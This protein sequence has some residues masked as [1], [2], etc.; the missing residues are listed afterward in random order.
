MENKEVAT[1]RKITGELIGGFILYSIPFMILYTFI[2]S[3]I[4]SLIPSSLIL[5]GIISIFLQGLIVF[6]IWKCSILTTFRK[7]AINKDDVPTVMKNLFIFTFILCIIG[8]V[9]FSFDSTKKIN[10]NI[11]KISKST[12]LFTN[13]KSNNVQISQ[14]KLEKEKRINEI[15]T[16]QYIYLAILEIGLFIVYIGVVPLQ[17]KSI[18]KYAL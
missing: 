18:L 4:S 7:R 2:F 8:I 5:L 13:N 11:D 9:T 15:K 10:K 16:K 6:F 14:Y 1:V 3:V 12:S 17:K